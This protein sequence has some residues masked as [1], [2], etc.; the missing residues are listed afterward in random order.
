MVS[1]NYSL[2]VQNSVHSGNG[3]P[4]FKI[5]GCPVGGVAIPRKEKP[6][7]SRI[8]QGKAAPSRLR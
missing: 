6:P 3:G 2:L 1:K 8:F 7:P 5:G 4:I